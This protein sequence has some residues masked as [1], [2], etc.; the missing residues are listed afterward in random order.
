MCAL[1]K[2]RIS[3]FYYR[4]AVVVVVVTVTMG[5]GE[6]KEETVICWNQGAETRGYGGIYSPNNLTA[7][8]Y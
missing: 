5:V 8:P 7:F 3:I 1:K 2:K 6:S 4:E